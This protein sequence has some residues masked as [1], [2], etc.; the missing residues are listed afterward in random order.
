MFFIQF[1]PLRRQRRWSKRL[2]GTSTANP[3]QPPARKDSGK[4]ANS[5]RHE[6]HTSAASRMNSSSAHLISFLEPSGATS[7]TVYVACVM[8]LER[9]P[10]GRS[11]AAA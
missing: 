8:I 7:V 6:E 5:L 10:A 4:L 11:S 2:S 3:C 9:R 1:E